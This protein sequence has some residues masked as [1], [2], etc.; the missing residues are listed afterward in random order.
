MHILK[1]QIPF[2]FFL[3]PFEDPSEKSMKHQE[4]SLP[5]VY[6]QCFRL[7]GAMWDR[8]SGLWEE[9]NGSCNDSGH[10]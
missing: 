7:I 4:A 6:R 5:T 2:F 9:W 10:F 8:D 1:N 3:L